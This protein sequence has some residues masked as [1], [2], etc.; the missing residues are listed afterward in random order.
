MVVN[1]C[2]AAHALTFGYTSDKWIAGVTDG[3]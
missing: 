1:G 3:A 2:D